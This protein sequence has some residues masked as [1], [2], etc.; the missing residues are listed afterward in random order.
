MPVRRSRWSICQTTTPRN[1]TRDL[2]SHSV[3]RCSGHSSPVGPLLLQLCFSVSPPTVARPAS[4]PLLLRVPSQGLAC[5]AGCWLPE[6]VSDLAPLR[7][8]HLLGHWFL[9]HLLPHLFISDLLLS[10][11]FVDAPQTGVE[12]CLNLLLHRLCCQ[13]CLTSVE[14]D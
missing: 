13:P 1:R 8:W 9:S 14:Q 10:S 6:G 3:L 7:P 5:G 12:E 4:L 2:E 11:D